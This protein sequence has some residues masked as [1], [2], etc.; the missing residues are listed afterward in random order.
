MSTSRPAPPTP[1][2]ARL[3]VECL[4]EQGCDRIFTVPGESF[5]PVL[6]ALHDIGAI[7]VVT[8]RQEG[9]AAFMAC[10]DGAM[11]GRPGVCFVTR[12]PGATNASIGV[13]VA[14][15]DSQPMILFVGD[16][17]S[18]MRDREGFQELDF[19]AFFGPAC[20]WAARIDSAD[21]IPEYIVRAYSTAIS[22]RPGPVVLALPEDMLSSATRSNAKPRPFVSRPV[23]SPS[24]DAMQAMMPLIAEAASP[25]AIV[26]G[27]G[28]NPD[29]REHFQNYAETIGLPVATAFRRQDAISPSSPVYAGNLGYGPNPKLVERVKNADLVLAVGARLG[30]A[31]TDGYTVPPL[32]DAKRKLIHVHPDPNEL[33]SVYPTD[34]SICAS[35][36][37]FAKDAA[38]LAGRA[39]TQSAAGSEAHAE[40]EAWATARPNDHALDMGACVAFMLGTLPADTIICNGA[41]NFSGWWH[42]YWRYEG[43]PTQLAPTAGAM[44][45]GVPAAVAAARRFPDRTVVAVAG[46]GDFLMNGQELATAVQHDCNLI[47]IVVD[48]SAYGTIRMHQEREF[49]ERV[50]ATELKNPDFAMLASSFGGWSAT[51]KT[52]EEFQ[53]ALTQ[54]KGL[55]G[56]RLI[57]CIIEI[58]QLAASGASISG[59]RSG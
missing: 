36:D 34:L 54:A 50:S 52:T 39:I 25:I 9:G 32:D 56:L 53:T 22:G 42:R 1:D 11:T 47:V 33:G 20:K 48:N 37:E 59:L 2:A 40:W 26:G 27:A 44:G 45:Y 31:T 28:W 18:Q 38:L 58:E 15:Q 5:L 29:A 4:A 35:M 57:H 14:M 10:A 16:V 19:A 17:D 49:P 3:L 6:D 46:D 12:G 30:E 8:C 24:P 55:S 23:Q 7:D 43:F 51:A 21:R 41:G 13:H